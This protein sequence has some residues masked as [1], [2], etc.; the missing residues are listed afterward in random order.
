MVPLGGADKLNR[1]GSTLNFHYIVVVQ[2]DT[3]LSIQ[4]DQH[5][6]VRRLQHHLNLDCIGQNQGPL[7]QRIRTD[8]IENEGVEIWIENRPP[9]SHRIRRGPRG[10]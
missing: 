6:F 7:S 1:C 8:G 10:R 2:G 5:V 3:D 9:G 4:R